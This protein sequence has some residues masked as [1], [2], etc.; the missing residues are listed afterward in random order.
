M[1]CYLVGFLLAYAAGACN[2]SDSGTVGQTIQLF[3]SADLEKL[4]STNPDHYRRAKELM[5]AANKYCPVGKPEAQ[6]AD[7]RSDQVTCGH[8][9]MTSNPPKRAIRFTLDGAHYIAWVTL[10][11]SPPKPVPAGQ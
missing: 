4:H 7:L 10:T 5:S 8:L 6:S 11:A 3:T 1:K 2:A 9:D